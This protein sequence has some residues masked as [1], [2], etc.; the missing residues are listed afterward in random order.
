MFNKKI[1]IL[2]ELDNFT[3]DKVWTNLGIITSPT[4]R[5]PHTRGT[6]M[7]HSWHSDDTLMATSRLTQDTLMAP[8]KPA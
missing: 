3:L 5:P 7:A 2:E 6:F 1:S 4:A 8:L